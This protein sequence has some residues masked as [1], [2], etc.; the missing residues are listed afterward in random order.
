M[1]AASK[2]KKTPSFI[3]VYDDYSRNKSLLLKIAP[4]YDFLFDFM[5]VEK[6][7]AFR[8]LKNIHPRFAK[9][10]EKRETRESLCP[11]KSSLY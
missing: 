1:L 10:T 11:Y 3:A 8:V 6:T 5:S 4:F 9:M 7:F 2:K